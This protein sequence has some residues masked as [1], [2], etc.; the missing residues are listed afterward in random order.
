MA[1]PVDLN[2]T[3]PVIVN[4]SQNT[5]SGGGSAQ[6]VP[7]RQQNTV[8][9]EVPESFSKQD[10]VMISSEALDKSKDLQQKLDIQSYQHNANSDVADQKTPDKAAVSVA[11]I[12]HFPPFMGDSESLQQIKQNSP[13]LYREILKMMVPPPVNISYLDTM[14][15]RNTDP[16]FRR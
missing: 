14:E 11:S 1:A 4:I 9:R 16:A 15:L 13:A 8:S 5:V 7:Y 3:Q 2:I 12:K 6:P 10:T